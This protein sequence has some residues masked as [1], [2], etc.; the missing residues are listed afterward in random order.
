ML[1]NFSVEGFRSLRNFSL[2]LRPGLNILVGP[3]GAG[4]TNIILFFDFLRNLTSTSLSEAIGQAGG[5]AQVFAKR[6][7]NSFAETISISLQ[8]VVQVDEVNYR[9]SLGLDLKFSQ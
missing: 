3:N 5:I 7:K 6:G 9:Y 2:D 1:Q 8:G 4:K